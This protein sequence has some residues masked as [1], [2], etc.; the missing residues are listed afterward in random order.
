MGTP[1]RL[2]RSTSRLQ[3]HCLAGA[4]GAGSQ[5]VAIGE[6]RQQRRVHRPGVSQWLTQEAMSELAK[7]I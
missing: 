2:T 1:I 6:G 7:K 5:A 3:G 4:R